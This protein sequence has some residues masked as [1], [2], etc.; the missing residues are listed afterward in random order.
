MLPFVYTVYHNSLGD[1]QRCSYKQVHLQFCCKMCVSRLCSKNNDHLYRRNVLNYTFAK[2][3]NLQAKCWNFSLLYEVT[4]DCFFLF[5][6]MPFR[7]ISVISISVKKTLPY[8]NII[9][10]NITCHSR[11]KAK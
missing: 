1:F 3:D 11:R 10:N 8:R 4:V 9:E 6:F 2:E 5:L 7:P